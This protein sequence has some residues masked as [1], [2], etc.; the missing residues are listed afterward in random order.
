MKIRKSRTKK[1]L[2]H[3]PKAYKLGR[4]KHSSLFGLFI[5]DKEKNMKN[6]FTRF[7]IPYSY[8]TESC[9]AEA[10]IRNLQYKTFFHHY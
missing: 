1:V 2:S 6:I 8:F 10:E 4:D 7:D 3:W 5:G 9:T